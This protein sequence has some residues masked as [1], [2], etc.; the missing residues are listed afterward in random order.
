[1]FQS[2]EGMS[3]MDLK[4]KKVLI[5]GGTSGMGSAAALAIREG[6]VGDHRAG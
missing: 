1:M 3:T 6:R 4:D 2:T 5:T